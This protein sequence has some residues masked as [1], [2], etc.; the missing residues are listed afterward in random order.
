ME[1][2]LREERRIKEEQAS[3]IFQLEKELENLRAERDEERVR[4][5]E[6][7]ELLRG[8]VDK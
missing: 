3:K 2:Q 7:L 1:L 6:D 8:A 5:H 4:Y